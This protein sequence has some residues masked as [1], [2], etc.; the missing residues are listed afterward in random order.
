MQTVEQ[1]SIEWDWN[2]SPNKQGRQVVDME[3]DILWK[4]TKAGQMDISL[5]IW[6]AHVFIQVNQ[7]FLDVS[8]FT[9]PTLLGFFSGLGLTIPWL[10]EQIEKIVEERKK[11]SAQKKPVS[12]E[13]SRRRVINELGWTALLVA[14]GGVSMWIRSSIVISSSISVGKLLHAFKLTASV[15]QVGWS[16]DGS[17]IAAGSFDRT[18]RVWEATSG[19]NILVYRGHSD[20]VSTIA[21]SPDGRYIASGSSDRTVRVWEATSGHDVFV[22]KGHSQVVNAVAWS[23]DGRYIV[24]G[25][26]DKTVQVWEAATGHNVI[27][28]N[29]HSDSINSV[30]WSPDG[31]YVASGSTDT[32]VQIWEAASGNYIRSYNGHAEEVITVAWSSNGSRIASADTASLQVWDAMSGNNFLTYYS[33]N[34]IHEVAWSPDNNSLACSNGS[35]LISGG[36]NANTV[37][38]WDVGNSSVLFTYRG[39]S[40][41][42][43]TV[44][45]S[46]DG[47][48]VGSGGFDNT[49]QIWEA[50]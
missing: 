16:S 11:K 9:I 12:K 17:R 43:I 41:D 26:F 24:S 14:L 47:R 30:T 13:I 21:W 31:R 46:P 38:I 6:R 8:Q 36:G 4:S 45:W 2:I 5:P 7:A 39:H 33:Y 22:Y 23:P 29:G 32:T 19:H 18:V 37:Q 48:R 49:V 50:H 1:S 3:I 20:S 15:S 27:T 44:V 35:S 42:V 25:S 40:A 28:Y 10:W 34:F